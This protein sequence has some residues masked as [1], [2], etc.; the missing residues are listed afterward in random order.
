[1]TATVTYETQPSA[2]QPIRWTSTLGVARYEYLMQV[3]RPAIWVVSV[4]L[5]LA[6]AKGPGRLSA[7]VSLSDLTASWAVTFNLF[8]PLGVGVLLAD[9]ARRESR[10]GLDDLLW[11]TPAGLGPRWW[12]KAVGAS[13]ATITPIFLCW[14]VLLIDL[15]TSRGLGAIP[16]GLGAFAAVA[17]PGLL[18]VASCSLVIPL[19]IGPALYRVGF[20][21]YWFWGNL[22]N[23]KRLPV[24]TVAGTPFEAIGEYASGGWFGGKT[25][26]APNRGIHLDPAL[27]TVNVAFLIGAALAVLAVAHIV[28]TRRHQP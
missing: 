14:I 26:E 25:F 18:F 8:A 21:G 7:H 11:S 22:L 6:A 27:A 13:A 4:L 19:L 17:L 28:L 16:I 12:G 15:A 10:L 24:P 9:R 5:I 3:R 23:T 1:L 20:I 2:L